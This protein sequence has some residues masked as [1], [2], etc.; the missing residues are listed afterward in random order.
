[1][2]KVLI[3]GAGFLQT[4]LI[5]RANELGYHTLVLDKNPDSVGFQY[6]DDYSNIDITCA[7]ECLEFARKHDVDGVITAATDYGVLSASYVSENMDLPGLSYQV[8]SMIK[9]KY[10]TRKLLVEN[11]VD[12]MDNFI[13]VSSMEDIIGIEKKI[14]Y[15]AMVKPVDGSG[16][17]GVRRVDNINELI[18]GCKNAFTSSLSGK[19][20]IEEFIDGKEY[21]VEAFVHDGNIFILGIMDK[22]MTSPPNYAELGHIIPS[23]IKN[24]KKVKSIVKRAIHV[25]GINFGAVNMDILVTNDGKVSIIDIGAR[26]G[27]NLISSHIIPQS[28]NY[29]YLGNF[30]K[31]SVGEPI[32]YPSEVALVKNVS[33]RILALSPGKIISLPN[34]EEISQEYDIEIFFNK[35]IGDTI[36]KYRN[37]LDG[38]GYIL[39]LDENLMTANHNMEK[40]MCF[41]NKQINKI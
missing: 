31:A 2:K 22:I 39:C 15:P 11:A 23:G 28:I 35:K 20:L 32:D 34:F 36:K 6:S 38:C 7:E 41:I 1:M 18:S 27:G 9:N 40:A 33:T 8:A 19:V 25:L 10:L 26:M 37:N 13:E 12:D 16:S 14:T 24:E 3:L 30:I 29:D 4:F 17:K 5:K 21:G